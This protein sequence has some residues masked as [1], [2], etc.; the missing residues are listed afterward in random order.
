MWIGHLFY[1]GVPALLYPMTFAG[2]DEL[3]YMFVAWMNVILHCPLILYSLTAIFLVAGAA[4]LQEGS[5]I[6]LA[7]VWTVNVGYWA[8]ASGTAFVQLNYN[9]QLNEWYFGRDEE[10]VEITYNE[11]PKDAEIF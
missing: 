3:D 8:L 2:V 10:E 4:T 1:F 5:Y 7:E 6:T 9:G 11:I